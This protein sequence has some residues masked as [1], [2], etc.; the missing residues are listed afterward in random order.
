MTAYGHPE[1][2]PV[3][4]GSRDA[5][6]SFYGVTKWAAERAVL[7]SATQDLRPLN[8]V[9]FRMFNVYGPRQSLTN[10]YQGVLGI[11]LGRVL[12][13]E[14]IVVHGDGE[15]SRDFVYVEDVA[16][17]WIAALDHPPEE[18]A[19]INLGTCTRTTIN[20][21]WKGAVKAIGEN[22]ETWPMERIDRRPGD[23][24]HM[25]ADISR[26]G[27]LLGWTPQITLPEGLRRTAEWARQ[28]PTQ[29]A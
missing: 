28:A 20:D 26:A 4:E 15:Q 6:V 10:P 27:D 29:V 16:R 14:S 19:V 12:R 25:V 5:P 21:L 8:A 23:Q 3:K 7:V 13:G 18:A 2:L 9:C 17:A 1:S 11:F 22:P 24:D